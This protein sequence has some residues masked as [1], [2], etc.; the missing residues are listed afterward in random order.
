MADPRHT[1]GQRGELLAERFLRQLGYQTIARR[2]TT[3][4][5]E[6]DLVMRAGNT[7]VFVEVKTRRD[8]RR[9]DPEDAVTAAKRAKLF[10]AAAW[11]LHRKRWEARPCRFDVVAIILPENGEPEITHHIAAFEPPA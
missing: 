6:L 11:L 7:V 10:K 8:R 5:G 9:A 2:Y 3:P 1:S 4:V